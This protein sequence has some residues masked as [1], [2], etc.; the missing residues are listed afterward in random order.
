MLETQQARDD[1]GQLDREQI[2][3][4]M[5][6]A[7]DPPEPAPPG[8][9]QHANAPRG[10][11]IGLGGWIVAVLLIIALIFFTYQAWL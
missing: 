10:A 9:Y 11:S 7:A 3:E 2:R 8:I 5:E 6:M 1:A 4:R